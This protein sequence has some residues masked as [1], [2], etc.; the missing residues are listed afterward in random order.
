MKNRMAAVVERNYPLLV[1]GA[2]VGMMLWGSGTAFLLV[3]ALKP[4]A[5]DFNWPR[6]VPSV[7]LSLYFVGAGIGGIIMGHWMDRA[8]M[9]KPA[10]VAALAI[11]CGAILT[12]GVGAAWQLFA[13][14]GLLMGFLGHGALFPPL[15]ANVIRWF[16][17]RRGT[18][19]GIVASGQSIAGMLWPPVFR[20]VNETAGWR[21]TFLWFGIGAVLLMVPLSLILRRR[22]PET[23]AARQA[24]FPA[25]PPSRPHLG[26]GRLPRGFTPAKLQ[27]SLS[28]A[29]VCCCVAMSVPT[30]HLVAHVS[31]LGHPTSRAAEMLSVALGASLLSRVS[32]IGLIVNRFGGLTS[33]FVFSS[34]QALG[35]AF[36]AWIDDLSAL[37][38]VA[39]VFGVGYGGIVPSYPVVVREFL[40]AHEGG[41][42]TAIVILFGALG[43]AIGG[44]MGGFVFDLTGFYR[45]AFLIGFAFNLGNLAVI[46]TLIRLSRRAAG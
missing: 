10:L 32:C 15:M 29:I 31:D 20:Y 2:S 37:Y 25:S 12:S 14:Y 13:I 4:I 27:A 3:V 46:G 1:L 18:A 19:V 43:M 16:D 38:V 22:P 39:F 8:G 23:P 34:I 24:R 41:R 9:G 45:P 17:H 21:E 33:I 42:R 40:P 6:T 11:G 5:F 26:A 28:L 30:G 36:L 7:A 35:L 44:W